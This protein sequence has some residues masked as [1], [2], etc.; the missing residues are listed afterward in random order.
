VD[1]VTDEHG[2][3][4][5][6]QGEPIARTPGAATSSPRLTRRRLLASVGVA[7]GGLA[8]TSMPPVM[9]ALAASPAPTGPTPAPAAGTPT[10]AP[11]PSETARRTFRSRPDLHPP[12]V[13]VAGP[14]ADRGSEMILLTPRYGGGGEGVA[15]FDASGEL[16]WMRRV[17]GRAAADLHPVTWR[18]RPALAWWEGSI[19]A[20]LGDGEFVLVDTT[21]R[22]IGRVRTVA[23]PA[24]LHELVLTPEG[25][26]YAFAM[27]DT[28]RD[29]RRLA[30]MLIQEIEVETGRLRWEWRASDHIDLA[31]SSEPVPEEGPWDWIHFNAIDLEPNGD[32][33]LSARHT[34]AIYRIDRRTGEVRWRLG[35]RRSDFGLP[36]AARF[37]AQHDIRRL[38]DGTVSLFD[39]GTKDPKATQQVSRGLVLRLDERAMT[40][41]VVRELRPPHPSV[42]SSQGNL[43]VRP[44]G[45]AF[46]GWGSARYA[47]GYGPD[48]SVRL[49]ASM[50]EGWSSYRAYRTPWRGDPADQPIVAAG[51]DPAGDVTAWVSWN[52][53]TRVAG[54]QLL[55]GPAG[56]DLSA[57]GQPVPRDGFET[58]LRVPADATRVAA[59]ALDRRG[60]VLGTSRTALVATAGVA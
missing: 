21:Y 32:L 31:E 26:A 35:G 4:T 59:R 12:V 60:R 54:W 15:V 52:G 5:A 39:N 55:A 37:V 48:G 20:G 13:S 38:G 43:T 22:E 58:A 29:G 25:R 28:T 2:S 10:P 27:D 6:T 16:V 14:A 57:V 53:A 41:D 56:D 19:E 7:A 36:D 30:D 50:P 17:P 49:D 11:D 1:V 51:R 46:I 23:R 9:R 34:D 44:D 3:A 40:A 47:T 24:D 33:L 8:L 45:S 42:S 18:G